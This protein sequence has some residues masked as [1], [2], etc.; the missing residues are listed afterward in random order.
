MWTHLS[1]KS[2][3]RMMLLLHEVCGLYFWFSGT[4][5]C[6]SDRNS[7]NRASLL[8]VSPLIIFTILKMYPLYAKKLTGE[9]VKFIFYVSQVIEFMTTWDT[10]FQYRAEMRLKSQHSASQGISSTRINL[11]YYM[12]CEW[13]R[14]KREKLGLHG[15]YFSPALKKW[16]L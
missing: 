8:Y 5:H 16:G 7:L 9:Q 13:K 1:G 15:I 12:Y 3:Y 14:G 4:Y 11:L 10:P 2:I 6:H